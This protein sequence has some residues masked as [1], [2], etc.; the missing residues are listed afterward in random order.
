MRRRVLHM[1]STGSLSA[2]SNANLVNSSGASGGVSG[3]GAI[4][5]RDARLAPPSRPAGGPA[6][7]Q[8]APATAPV[9]PGQQLPRG[10]LL[11]LSV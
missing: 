1:L 8:S 3:A 4:P 2:F 6:Q 10:S 5:I 11:N 9:V 7:T